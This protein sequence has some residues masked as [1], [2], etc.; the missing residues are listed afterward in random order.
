MSRA[1]PG[2][3]PSCSWGTRGRPSFLGVA[4]GV[5]SPTSFWVLLAGQRNLEMSQRLR[6]PAR[7]GGPGRT[8]R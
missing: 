1:C 5:V 7:Q 3:C 2:H 4:P 8:E 6:I